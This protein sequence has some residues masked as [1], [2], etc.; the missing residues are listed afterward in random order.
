M[1]LPPPLSQL[2]PRLNKFLNG[3][4]PRKLSAGDLTFP[5]CPLVELADG[6]QT[7]VG[8]V[9]GQSLQVLT[10]QYFLLAEVRTPCHRIES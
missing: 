2:L 4:S 10:A 7:Q 8:K 9:V 3:T 1:T 6:A 5:I